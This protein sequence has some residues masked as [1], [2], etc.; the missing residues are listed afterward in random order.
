MR[1]KL[2]VAVMLVVLGSSLWAGEQGE[3]KL[4][5]QDAAEYPELAKR[6]NIHGTVKIKVWISRAG[7]VTRLE[8]IGGNPVLVESSLKAVKGWKY[9]GSSAETTTVVEV[10]F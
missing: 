4:V 5:R 1:D 3:R 2:K 7:D 8:Y 9:E 10:K 6:N